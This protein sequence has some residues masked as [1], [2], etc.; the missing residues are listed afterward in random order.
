MVAT[1]LMFA[2]TRQPLIANV[3][4]LVATFRHAPR[5]WFPICTFGMWFNR[6]SRG[7]NSVWSIVRKCAIN[8]S[9]LP[10]KPYRCDFRRTMKLHREHRSPAL[11]WR[12]S[13]RKH[14]FAAVLLAS[15][16]IGLL[17]TVL[18]YDI[19]RAWGLPL[20]YKLRGPL[21]PPSEVAI[22]ALDQD[23]AGRLKLPSSYA[24]W[25]RRLH[26]KLVRV[27]KA[28]GAKVIAYDVVFQ[29]TTLHTPEENAEFA[30]AMRDAGNVILA[31]EVVEPAAFVQQGTA[32]AKAP[33]RS[34]AI[35]IKFCQTPAPALASAAV[36]VAPFL[37]SEQTEPADIF[38]TTNPAPCNT[39]TLPA[40][41]LQLYTSESPK[42]LL[43]IDPHTGTEARH[44]N[45]RGPPLTVPTYRLADALSIQSD[46]VLW[47]NF[48]KEISGKVIFVGA[49]ELSP[50]AQKN[51]SDAFDTVFNDA[52][53]LRLQGVELAA[54]AFINL[55]HRSDLK[56]RSRY[57]EMSFVAIAGTVFA[58]GFALLSGRTASLTGLIVLSAYTAIAVHQ[59]ETA[60]IWNPLI[61][62]LLL[63]FVAL[64][65]TLATKYA[66]LIH[67]RRQQLKTWL[68]RLPGPVV[69]EYLI[70]GRVHCSAS[71][72]CLISDLAN[73]TSMVDSIP[74]A[75]LADWMAEYR[76]RTDNLLERYTG[77]KVD[78][79]GDGL[80]ALWL[81]EKTN[82]AEQRKRAC[83]CALEML[84]IKVNALA[85]HVQM[86]RLRIGL[87]SGSMEL[88]DTGDHYDF[89]LTAF[90][91]VPPLA[92]RLENLNKT[93]NTQVIATK[94]FARTLPEFLWRELGIF[95]LEGI[96][97]PLEAFECL[98]RK[99]EASENDRRRCAA[100]A[101][102]L[103]S[104]RM[105]AREKAEATFKRILDSDGTDGPAQ[106]Y[107]TH[108]GK[109]LLVTPCSTMESP[110]RVT[111]TG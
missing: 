91:S 98:G 90:G 4:N 55:L 61:I 38:W 22:V 49:S 19:E 32:V 13:E 18:P 46:P 6:E 70:T 78:Q 87:H 12:V 24:L 28:A 84:S 21:A 71:G 58:L 76:S 88:R 27:L 77:Y 43:P 111:K 42:K 103:A 57:V 37:V 63:F 81:D 36:A 29:D 15:V 97:E 40:I 50:E 34:Q 94:D 26:A 5:G 31:S 101:Q 74:A 10:L 7:F 2:E 23:S 47:A 72:V 79:A 92:S 80:C 52:N 56:R 109:E 83:L 8:G 1:T 95:Q 45:L 69:R 102:A 68:G 105:G 39:P 110:I 11:P 17:L 75:D 73:W 3:K 9:T 53:G 85:D 65:A 25:S 59:F 106:F 51:S 33:N 96:D 60:F 67:K 20:L 89:K 30:A 64:L 62:P 14:V 48:V 66:N 35:V 54:N 108:L 44:F 99:A 16:L 86:P 93:L 107:L 41:A 100:F 104:C 82:Q